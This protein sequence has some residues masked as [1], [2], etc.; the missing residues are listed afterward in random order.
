MPLTSNQDSIS[1]DR[2][3]KAIERNRAKQAKKS[4]LSSLK[5]TVNSSSGYK[6]QTM[7]FSANKT[8]S[9]THVATH[10]MEP[11]FVRPKRAKRRV[12]ANKLPVK[13]KSTTPTKQRK[14]RKLS[15][16][17]TD[18]FYKVSWG[19]LAIIALRLIF[20]ERGILDYFALQDLID[21]KKEMIVET[22]NENLE[23]RR[24]I[25]LIRKDAHYQRKVVRDNLGFISEN[26]YLVVFSEES[27]D[28]AN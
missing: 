25:V 12:Q 10:N 4:G 17:R 5:S 8:A 27:G 18:L 11:E 2:L 28:Q 6:Q 21:H 23:L 16:K 14:K 15:K 20:A 22:Q 13:A 24:E 1:S 19:F 3:R 9:R 7:N 26:E